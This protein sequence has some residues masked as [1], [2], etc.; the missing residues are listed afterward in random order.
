MK[1]TFFQINILIFEIFYVLY[2][3]RNLG[4][5]FRKT[6]GYAIMLY[7]NYTYIRLPEYESLGSKHVEDIKNLKKSEK[8]KY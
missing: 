5:I 3:L 8:Q 1:Y 6:V 7:H 2:I 4:F